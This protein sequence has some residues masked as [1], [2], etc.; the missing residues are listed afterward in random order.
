MLLAHNPH[1]EP[2]A[3]TE[4]GV[5]Y[6]T[7]K[8][9]GEAGERETQAKAVHKKRGENDTRVCVHYTNFV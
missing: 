2:N 6:L 1:K 5:E 4:I 7:R 3:Q 8:R 9:R